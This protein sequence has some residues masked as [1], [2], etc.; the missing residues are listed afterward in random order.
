MGR[1]RYSILND[2]NLNNPFNMRAGE[3]V[4]PVD[5]YRASGECICEACGKEYWKH[6]SDMENLGW[7][8]EPFLRVLCNNDRVKL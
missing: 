2:M 3:Q 7:N 8:D 5:F 4:E 1:G 6:P